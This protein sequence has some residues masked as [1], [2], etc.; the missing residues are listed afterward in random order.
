[1]ATVIGDLIEGDAVSIS[2]LTRASAGFPASV[3]QRVGYLLDLM[4]E[5]VDTNIDLVPLAGLV[6]NSP[7]TRL[8]SHAPNTGDLSERWR[9]RVNVPIE[10]D[11]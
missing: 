4:A 6:R 10:H 8:S 7:I 11:L 9:V 2:E 3:V 5:V 1:M